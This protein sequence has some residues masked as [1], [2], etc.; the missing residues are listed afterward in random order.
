MSHE[1]GNES[2][3]GPSATGTVREDDRVVTPAKT[4]A[5]AA[6]ALVFGVSALLSVLTIILGPLGLLLGVIGVVLGVLGIRNA[7]RPG[8]TGKGVAIGGL[9]LSILAVLIGGAIALGVTFFL[10]NEAALDR[11]E[12]EIGQELERYRGVLPEDV[13]P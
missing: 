9:V 10:N 12:Q 13:Q 5:A 4:S 2:P 1:Y 7:R 3:R 8:V 11:L 6:F